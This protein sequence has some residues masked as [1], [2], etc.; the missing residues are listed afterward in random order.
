MKGFSKTVIAGAL[1]AAAAGASA[2]ESSLS[3]N[4]GV[5]SDYRFRGVSQSAKDPALQGGVDYADKSGFYVG[6]WASTID[7]EGE[8][9]LTPDPDAGIEVDLYGGYKM[10]AAGIDWDVGLIYYGYPGSDSFYDLPFFEVYGKGTYGPVNFQLAYT[11]DYTG[12]T[13]ES[14]L[15][16]A[17]GANFDLGGGYTLGASVGQSSGDGIDATF[18]DSYLDYKI[19]VSKEF[20]GFGF[21]LS[22]IDTDIDPEI[23]T[24]LF[25][26]EGTVVL[27]VTKTF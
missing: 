8:F 5:V 10:K 12:A 6:A 22:Y 24:D 17:V 21:N 3:Y 2:A 15:Y 7:F 1:L 14:A 11:D 26:S 25:N 9:T 16:I 4:V 18:L 19:G 13:K 23:K 27:T 20:A